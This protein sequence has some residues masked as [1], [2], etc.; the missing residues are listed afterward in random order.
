MKIKLYCFALGCPR[1]IE[2]EQ[3]VLPTIHYTCRNHTEK[4]EDKVR[5]QEAQFDHTLG[6]TDPQAYERGGRLRK[7]NK[8]INR[9][10]VS[11][12]SVRKRKLEENKKALEGHANAEAILEILKKKI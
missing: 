7:S 2:V 9:D 8:S 6:G 3:A 4:G 5:F 12:T 1:F 10:G 11:S